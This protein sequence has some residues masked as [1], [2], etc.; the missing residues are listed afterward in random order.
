MLITQLKAKETIESLICGKA[1]VINCHGCKEVAFPEKEA[2]ELQKELMDAGKLTGILSLVPYVYQ[3]GN[4]VIPDFEA[5][6]AYLKGK[7]SI[8]GHMILFFALAMLIRLL[9]DRNF[10][11]MIRKRKG[12]K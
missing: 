2:C 7:A 8:R 11:R 5:D 4:R 9:K 3:R 6:K 1:F 12:G 10:R